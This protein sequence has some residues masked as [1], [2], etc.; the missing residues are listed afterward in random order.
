MNT[1]LATAALA[2]C[3]ALGGCVTG[4]P[5]SITPGMAKKYLKPGITH[6]SE[7][8]ERFGAPNVITFRNG[9]EMWVYD[10]VSSHERG[11]VFGIAGGAGAAGGLLGGGLSS[12]SRSEI[13]VMLIVYYDANDV[14]ADYKITQTKF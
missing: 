4:R 9:N 11:G 10:K 5:T 14:V 7:V 3:L 13:S 2:A 8:I 6:L 12:H 1:R